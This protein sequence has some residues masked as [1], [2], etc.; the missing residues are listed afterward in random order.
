MTWRL[1]IILAG[2]LL[3]C[4]CSTPHKI[5]GNYKR[6]RLGA[7]AYIP[8][9]QADAWLGFEYKKVGGKLEVDGEEETGKD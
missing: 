7:G 3:L 1:A 9:I 2:L 4:G 6:V 8:T 5:E